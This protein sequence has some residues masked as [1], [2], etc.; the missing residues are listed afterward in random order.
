METR[1]SG[2]GCRFG[3]GGAPELTAAAPAAGD[4]F[5]ASGK[6]RLFFSAQKI[7]LVS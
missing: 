6:I 7:C 3:M 5:P 2:D 4:F 1:K